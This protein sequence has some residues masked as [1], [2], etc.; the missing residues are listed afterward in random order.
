[1][2]G[3]S[4]EIFLKGIPED[5]AERGKKDPLLNTIK[6]VILKHQIA[7]EPNATTRELVI[8][9]SPLAKYTLGDDFIS[10]DQHG[11]D[12]LKSVFPATYKVEWEK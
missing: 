5:L 4:G 11:V 7:G 10:T 12:F 2:A 3:F 9:V 6:R 8:A 1:M